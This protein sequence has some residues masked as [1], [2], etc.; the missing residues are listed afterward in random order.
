MRGVGG[1]VFEEDAFGSKE[2]MR[3]SSDGHLL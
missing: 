1:E 3:A 2:S